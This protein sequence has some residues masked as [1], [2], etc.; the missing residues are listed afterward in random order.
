M[1]KIMM[2]DGKIIKRKIKGVAFGNFQMNIVR[3]KNREY[4]LGEGDEYMRGY[5][6]VYDFRKLSPLGRKK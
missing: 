6:K 1:V 5:E 3:I 2:P 4:L